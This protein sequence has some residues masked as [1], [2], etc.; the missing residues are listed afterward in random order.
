MMRRLGDI[1]PVIA[2]GDSG[3]TM[4]MLTVFAALGHGPIEITS[5]TTMGTCSMCKGQVDLNDLL[6]GGGM[7]CCPKCGA[8][9]Y[10]D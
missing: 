8:V 5:G 9:I 4:R 3:T 1:H 10:R 2:C 6:V 7:I